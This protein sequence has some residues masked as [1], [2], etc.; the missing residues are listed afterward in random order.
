MIGLG[1]FALASGLAVRASV[2]PNAASLNDVFDGATGAGDALEPFRPDGRVE[3][4]RGRPADIPPD[5]REAAKTWGNAAQIRLLLSRGPEPKASFT[6]AVIGDMEPGRFAWER[7]F[8]P[9]KDAS[10]KLLKA[11]GERRPDFVFQLGDFV[12]QGDAAH[13]RAYLKKIQAEAP[14]PFLT[15]IGNHDRSRPNGDAD[16]DL[17]AALHGPGDF[18]LDYNGWRFIGLDTSDRVLRPDQVAWL[19]AALATDHRK[20]LFMHVPPHYLKGKFKGCGPK[21]LAIPKKKRGYFQ[22]VKAGYFTDGSAAFEE[23]VTARRVERVYVAHIHAFGVARYRGVTYVLTGGGGSPLYPM[24][25][26]EP[27][28]KMAHF[29]EAEARAA[30]LTETVRELDGSSFPLP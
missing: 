10:T 25:P 21:P 20:V 14:A 12:S 27:Q 3:T 24:P 2:S 8:T 4:V 9:G 22:D 17:Y 18:Y 13:Y 29:I 5:I 7:V 15:V 30:G 26:G 1:A 11:M 6:F 16:K 28:C 19:D 23:L